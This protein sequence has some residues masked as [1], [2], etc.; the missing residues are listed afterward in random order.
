MDIAARNAEIVAAIG[1]NVPRGVIA[2]RHD[3]SATRVQQ[4]AKEGGVALRRSPR[5]FASTNW[6]RA[7][8]AT[9]KRMWGKERIARI[10]Q[11]LGRT[12]NAVIGKARR[13]GL[14]RLAPARRGPHAR[15]KAAEVAS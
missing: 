2:A 10:A 11:R 7:D 12:R 8:V 13:L 1:R 4:I 3:L 15:R 6:P 14:A 5:R 9:L